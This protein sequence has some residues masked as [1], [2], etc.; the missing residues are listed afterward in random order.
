MNDPVDGLNCV[1]CIKH[2][3]VYVHFIEC[4]GECNMRLPGG[5]LL[6]E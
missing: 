5:G 1:P 3:A 4:K 6:G 2:A